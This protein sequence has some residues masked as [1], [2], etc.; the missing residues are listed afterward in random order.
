MECLTYVRHL[1]N[2][3]VHLF[4]ESNNID[5]RV[6]FSEMLLSLIHIF[7]K[8]NRRVPT[9][10]LEDIP[11]HLLLDQG[12]YS[13]LELNSN[14]HEGFDFEE[15][16][17]ATA[18]SKLPLMRQKI[19][20][21]LFVEEKKPYEIAKQLHCSVQYVYNQRSLAIKKLRDL[22]CKGGDLL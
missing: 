8:V 19:L 21:L 10:A 14:K 4:F 15:E 18:F 20:M 16:R 11:E 6:A 12:K 5:T 3:G 1:Q 13:A 17:L 22:L 2:I 7:R 9:I